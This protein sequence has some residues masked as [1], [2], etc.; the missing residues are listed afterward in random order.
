[1]SDFPKIS[2]L[3]LLNR[4]KNDFTDLLVNNIVNLDYNDKL[5]EWVI[6][7][8]SKK[9]LTTTELLKIKKDVE[10]M[11]LIYHHSRLKKTKGQ[12]RNELV[13]L[14]KYKYLINLDCDKIYFPTYIKHSL[15]RLK[16]TKS[17][18]VGS[19]NM[20]YIYP[21]LNYSMA[22]VKSFS[23][24]QIFEETM[25][26]TKKY[27]TSMGGFENTNIGEG[28]KLID[29]NTNNI[30]LTKPQETSVFVCYDDSKNDYL[31]KHQIFGEINYTYIH[32][33]NNTLNTTYNKDNVR[34]FKRE[35]ELKEE[36]LKKQLEE[37]KKNK[38]KS[39]LTKAEDERTKLDK[40][41]I[42]NLNKFID[43]NSDENSEEFFDVNS[44]ENLEE[45]N[46]IMDNDIEIINI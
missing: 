40:E 2:I 9:E 18:L 33:L 3:S 32:I 46:D 39:N 41:D 17:G 23:K 24:R 38:E 31:L 42:E 1:M 12:K 5:L 28:I 16:E 36:K 27:Y 22:H 15:Q 37:L 43:E 11:K 10:P 13:K 4:D 25:F 29:F 45:K 26:F 6:Y 19:L 30:E 7:D 35:A 44:D 8:D 34:N 14:S 21:K 20:L